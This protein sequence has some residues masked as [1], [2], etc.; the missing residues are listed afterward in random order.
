MLSNPKDATSETIYAEHTEDPSSWDSPRP[1]FDVERFNHEL[2]KRG[3]TVGS[4]PRFRLKWA[5]DDDTYCLNEVSFWTGYTYVEDGE[6]KFVSNTQLDF[7][8]PENAVVSP[9]YEYQKYYIPRWVVEQYTDGQYV[10]A[11]IIEQVEFVEERS[12]HKI[13]KSHYVEP[14]EHDLQMAEGARYLGETLTPQDIA[15]GLAKRNE[16]RRKDYLEKKREIKEDNKYWAD[17][18]MRDGVPER[19]ISIPKQVAPKNIK[20]QIAKI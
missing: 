7:V 1:S 5:P 3:G 15:E 9:H 20:E 14:A 11:W 2:E 18:Y 10:L 17:K 4:V 8:F 12:G 6:Q 13:C 19:V 16:V